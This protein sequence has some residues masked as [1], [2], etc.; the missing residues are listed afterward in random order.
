MRTIL[1]LVTVSI[2][3]AQESAKPQEAREGP[4]DFEAE[5][6][7]SSIF[8]TGSY[9]QPLWRGLGFDGHYFGGTA[10]DTGF[11]GA[12][13]TFR[14]RKLKLSPGFGTSENHLE[15]P[16]HHLFE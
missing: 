13:W 15:Q 16:G 5:F 11:T 1:V 3:L 6:A 8:R 2:A 9:L 4:A 14:I 12:S 10:T 7:A